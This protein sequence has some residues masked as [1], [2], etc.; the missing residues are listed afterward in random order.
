MF[1]ILHL[2]YITQYNLFYFHSFTS[3]VDYF[4]FLYCWRVVI[5]SVYIPH[6]HNQL[7]HLRTFKSFQFLSSYRYSN[8]EHGWVS[9]CGVGCLVLFGICLERWYYKSIFGLLKFLHTY[10]DNV[11]TVFCPTNSKRG[12][13]ASF[14]PYSRPVFVACC[15]IGL[16]HSNWGKMKSQCYFDLHFHNY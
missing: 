16:C 7:Q 14:F 12:C 13:E 5:H 2:G 1:V 6:F 3:K 9:V 11:S 10:F 15:S 8:S 4:I